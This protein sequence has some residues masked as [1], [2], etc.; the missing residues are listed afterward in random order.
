MKRKKA[1]LKASGTNDLKNG[2]YF[3]RQECRKVSHEQSLRCQRLEI[4]ARHPSRPMEL[5]LE[6]RLKI[7][8]VGISVIDDLLGY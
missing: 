8:G 7:I 4:P 6:M 3:L 1:L 2:C 5:N